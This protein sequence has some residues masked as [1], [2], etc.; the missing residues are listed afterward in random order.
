[1][2]LDVFG[3]ANGAPPK[4]ISKEAMNKLKSWSWPGNVR[5]LQN[6]IERSALLCASTELGVED[7]QIEGYQPRLKTE[8]FSVGMT[9]SEAERLLIMKTLEHTGQNRT[10][11]AHLLGISIRTLRNKLNEYK[12]EGLNEQTV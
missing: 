4:T 5:E 7:I 2:F 3:Q 10:Q 9:V 1:M 12:Q 8:G 11:A 6:V